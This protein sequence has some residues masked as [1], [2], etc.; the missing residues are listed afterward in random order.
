[1]A[2]ATYIRPVELFGTEIK[3]LF[4]VVKGRTPVALVK[5]EGKKLNVLS[6]QDRHGG[7]AGE[8]GMTAPAV[9]R[10]I[11]QRADSGVARAGLPGGRYR[12]S[13]PATPC[14]TRRRRSTALT[15]GY[16]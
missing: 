8:F 5:P 14:C 6:V 9:M 10:E 2:T 16:K 4:Q 1:M 7:K 15:P 13:T 12:R 3:G 11:R